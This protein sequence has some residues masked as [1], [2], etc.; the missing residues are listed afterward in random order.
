MEISRIAVRVF[1]WL[2]QE[3]TVKQTGDL[4]MRWAVERKGKEGKGREEMRQMMDKKS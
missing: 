2:C 3:L 1:L 4:W